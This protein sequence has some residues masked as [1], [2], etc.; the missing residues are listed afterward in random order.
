MCLSQNFVSTMEIM[1]Q[2]SLLQRE[3]GAVRIKVRVRI[4]IVSPMHNLYIWSKHWDRL[5]NWKVISPKVSYYSRGKFLSNRLLKIFCSLQ[6][7]YAQNRLKHFFICFICTSLYLFTWD[8]FFGIFSCLFYLQA[9]VKVYFS[10]SNGYADITLK[11][12]D[13]I[14][15]HHRNISGKYFN[16]NMV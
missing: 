15:L 7:Q 9:I 10:K 8:N 14:L 13:G 4:V 11:N 2:C 6:I 5:I 12:L 3:E 1:P 16:P